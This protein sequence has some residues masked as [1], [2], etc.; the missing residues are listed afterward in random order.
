MH[1]SVFSNF[2]G[3]GWVHPQ[4]NDRRRLMENSKKLIA[5]R[6]AVCTNGPIRP[7]KKFP[8]TAG[9]WRG[10]SIEHR[11]KAL[12]RWHRLL[13]PPGLSREILCSMPVAVFDFRPALAELMTR[14]EPRRPTTESILLRTSIPRLSEKLQTSNFQ[15]CWDRAVF[16]STYHTRVT[17]GMPS[18]TPSLQS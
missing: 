9:W 4:G 5:Q 15:S 14:V 7:Q 2:C 16:L 18:E 10:P 11:P 1:A 6:H 8:L 13:V 3:R 12:Q 17:C